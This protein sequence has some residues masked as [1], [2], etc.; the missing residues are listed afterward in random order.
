MWHLMQ[1]FYRNYRQLSNGEK[2]TEDQWKDFAEAAKVKRAD[3]MEPHQPITRTYTTRGAGMHVTISLDQK[4]IQDA[5]KGGLTRVVEVSKQKV[6]RL[7]QLIQDGNV[8]GPFF[9]LASGGSARN[10]QTRSQIQQICKESGFDV[11]FI[12]DLVSRFE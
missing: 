3:P 6:L 10:P 4:E 11:K 12:F 7:S 8:K 9:I 2:A 1:W 5:Y